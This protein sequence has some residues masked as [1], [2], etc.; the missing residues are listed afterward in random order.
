MPHIPGHQGDPPGVYK[1]RMQ[2]TDK[3][4]TALE[5]EPYVPIDTDV[6]RKLFTLGFSKEALMNFMGVEDEDNPVVDEAFKTI[7]SR[8]QKGDAPGGLVGY[9]FPQTYLP[10]TPIEGGKGK[11]SS[12]RTAGEYFSSAPG[13]WQIRFEETTVPD[14]F[15]LYGFEKAVLVDPETG[16]RHNKPGVSGA[17]YALKSLAE[18]IEIG[19]ETYDVDE[20][21][22]SVGGKLKPKLIELMR[23]PINYLF[24]EPLHSYFGHTVRKDEGL[25]KK[26]G[27]GQEHYAEHT[28]KMIDSVLENMSEKELAE[29]IYKALYSGGKY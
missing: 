19:G 14:T 5:Q 2:I 9:M 16:E 15:N 28:S 1:P 7:M 4:S 23:R 25:V 24:H 6:I 22:K 8:V 12:F 20:V 13:G 10:L 21:D 17:E 3:G 18:G 26:Y 11:K 27:Y 29:L